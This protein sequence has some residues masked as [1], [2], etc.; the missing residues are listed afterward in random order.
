M[1]SQP[2]PL[3]NWMDLQ[4]QYRY[5][6]ARTDLYYWFCICSIVRDLDQINK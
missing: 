2:S 5:K 6:Q 1:E 3:D 4:R